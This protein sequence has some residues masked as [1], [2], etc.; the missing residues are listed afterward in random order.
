MR[1]ISQ[2]LQRRVDNWNRN[3]PVGT[4]VTVTLD[5]GE[6]FVTTTR[7]LAWVM[8]GHSAMVMVDG[9]AGGYLID[10]VQ[11]GRIAS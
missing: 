2:Q 4:V 8:G 6:L 9:I 1:K 5:D 7:S 3:C 11:R 10:R